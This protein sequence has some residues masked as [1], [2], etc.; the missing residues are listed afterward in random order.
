MQHYYV[1]LKAN[2]TLNYREA[3]QVKKMELPT[4]EERWPW[5]ED[6]N[7]PPEG[8]NESDLIEV[9]KKGTEQE[10]QDFINNIEGDNLKNQFKI[11]KR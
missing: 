3:E 10:C 1:R 7:K 5:P 4:P 9:Y 2:H 8:N 11:I 6:K